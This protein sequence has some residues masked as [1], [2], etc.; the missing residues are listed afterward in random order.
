MNF[1]EYARMYEAEDS[2]WW[3][4]GLHT[5]ILETV[6]REKLRLGRPLRIFDAGCGTGRLCQLL[7]EQGHSASGCDASEE[8]LRFCCQ[9]GISEVFKADLNTLEL[10]PDAFDV[11][12][13]I[14]VLYHAGIADDVAVM[15]RLLTALKPGGL[16]ILNLVAHEFL[17]SSH[18]IAVHTRER[19]TRSMLSR[20]I[21]AAGFDRIFSSYRVSLLFPLIAAYR[22][23]IRFFGNRA[24]DNDAVA[25]DVALPHPL[26]NTLLLKSL[27]VENRLILS[28]R[29]LPTGSSVF[30]VAR[31]PGETLHAA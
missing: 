7:A 21:Q 6:R 29:I 15:R 23:G 12:T 31:K 8:A 25:S 10:E 22:I 13:S 2:H 3:Y 18:D 9:R 27:N 16:L 4:V 28:G 30:V 1:I 26:V 14:D 11:I 20:R 19:Y 17:R 24:A 5:L